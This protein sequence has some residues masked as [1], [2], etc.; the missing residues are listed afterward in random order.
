M[1]MRA[2]EVFDDCVLSAF[3]P[4]FLLLRNFCLLQ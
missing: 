1:D 4:I 2:I 3:R